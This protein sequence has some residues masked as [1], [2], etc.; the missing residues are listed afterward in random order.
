MFLAPA[1]DFRVTRNGRQPGRY[2]EKLYPSTSLIVVA[3]D[4]AGPLACSPPFL[5]NVCEDKMHPVLAFPALAGMTY[6]TLEKRG[7][8]RIV[9]GP[10]TF[11]PCLKPTVRRSA[12]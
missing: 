5:L 2:N 11:L 7:L 3:G 12:F 4:K 10:G 8:M 6:P 9:P 1:D